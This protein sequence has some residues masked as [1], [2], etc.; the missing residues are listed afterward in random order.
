MPKNNHRLPPSSSDLPK[1]EPA[2]IVADEKSLPDDLTAVKP[3]VSLP[4]SISV[5][6]LASELKVE[7]TEVIKKLI[8]GGVMAHINQ[9]L[10][11]ETAALVAQEFGFEILAEPPQLAISKSVDSANAVARPPI[12]TVMGHVDHG[13]TSLLDYIRQTK[14]VE[15]ESGGITQHIRAY[16]IERA[17]HDKKTRKITFID[18]PGHEAFSALRSHGANITDLV[19]LVVAADDGVKPQTVEALKFAQAANV[20]VIVA[21]N[22]IDLP[23]ANLERIKQQLVEIGLNPEDWG[24]RTVVAPVSALTGQGVSELLELVVLTTD[25]MEL[26]ADP[27][28][29]PEGIVIEANLDKT[30][31]PQTTLLIYNG[32]LRL[33]QVVVVGQTYGRVRAMNDDR[34]Q[35][36]IAAE[37]S[38][39]VTIIGLK[40]VPNFGDR[41]EVVANEKIART[42][43]TTS[44][45]GPT[46]IEESAGKTLN[47]IVKADVGGSLAAL[48]ET[49]GKLQ[50]NDAACQIVQ[51]G[52]GAVTENDLN[53]ARTCQGTIIAFR[54]PINKR[55][56]ELAVKE[57]II[58][59]E[60]WVIYE[61]LDYLRD[62]LKK[63]AT[64]KV[65]REIIGRLKILAIFNQAEPQ[66]VGGEVVEGEARQNLPVEIWRSKELIGQGKAGTL[67]VAKVEFKQVALGEQCGVAVV[68]APAIIKGDILHFIE[69]RP[70]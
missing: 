56:V 22:K 59:K 21:V 27:H 6:S 67:K 68:G 65:I 31:G 64:P 11:F 25:L 10:D 20:P 41:L 37:P 23:S 55:L 3:T 50:E 26:R 46:S 53:L 69:E 30:I 16:Q 1:A 42:L 47:L 18:T 5:R 63:I 40:E 32:T 36:I 60:Y 43:T 38:Q 28:A 19:I 15:G 61:A 62:Q 35:K 49:I 24:G 44:Q 8:A 17:G 52:I 34:G 48:K 51:A 12:V 9:S 66:I 70:Q 58:V 29:Q 54:V 2:S 33:G 4:N 7:A 14:V 39:P 57:Q 45:I 13:K